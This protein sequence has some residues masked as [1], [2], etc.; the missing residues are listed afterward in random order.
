[1]KV[2][3]KTIIF[4][5]LMIFTLATVSCSLTSAHLEKLQMASEVNL[6]TKQPLKLTDKFAATAPA[7]YITGRCTNAPEGTSLIAEWRYM[8]DDANALIDSASLTMTEP[9]TDFIF[10]VTNNNKNWKKG[11]Y[12]VRLFIDGSYVSSVPFSVE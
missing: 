7:F 4:S 8:E 9:D 11:D 1:M 10:K 12:E 6:E 2:V 5:I 3:K